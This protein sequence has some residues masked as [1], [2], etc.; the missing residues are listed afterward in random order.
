MV[1][2]KNFTLEG[3]TVTM[4]AR[5]FEEDGKQ[6]P[7]FSLFMKNEDENIG[8][9]KEELYARINLIRDE[10]NYIANNYDVYSMISDFLRDWEDDDGDDQ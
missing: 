10:L 3:D 9:T 8:L 4:V 2:I 7:C 6:R 1:K 5:V